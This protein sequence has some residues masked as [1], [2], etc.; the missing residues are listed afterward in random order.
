MNGTELLKPEPEYKRLQREAEMKLK[1][2]RRVKTEEKDL[3]R[4]CSLCCLLKYDKGDFVIVSDEYCPNFEWTQ[5]GKGNCKI[6]GDNV[7]QMVTRQHKCLSAEM[8]A[9]A[10]L[11]PN[12]CPYTKKIRGYKTRV[13]NFPGEV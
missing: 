4:R 7:G 5:A 3:C 6:Y 13:I 11:L 12:S 1:R 9:T 8:A 2:A 10:R